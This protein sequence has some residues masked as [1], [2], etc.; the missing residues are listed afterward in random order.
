M[1]FGGIMTKKTLTKRQMEKA[2]TQVLEEGFGAWNLMVGI[3]EGDSEL[4]G[5]PAK[6]LTAQVRYRAALDVW[7]H[8]KSMN[9]ELFLEEPLIQEKGSL[10]EP[11]EEPSTTSDETDLS[12]AEEKTIQKI[13]ETIANDKVSVIRPRIKNYS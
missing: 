3:M 1:T 9:P 11:S 13:K 10:A 8:F 4:T 5:I 12:N 2:V 7:K 6:E